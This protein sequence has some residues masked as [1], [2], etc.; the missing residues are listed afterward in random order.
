MLC[1]LLDWGR[2]I[3]NVR[4]ANPSNI[5]QDVTGIRFDGEQSKASY[6]EKSL[7]YL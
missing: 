3:E 2:Y 4:E 1:P 6:Q 5:V 7:L